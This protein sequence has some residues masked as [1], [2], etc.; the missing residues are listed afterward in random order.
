M[1][2]I[3]GQLGLN[4]AIKV[5]KLRISKACYAEFEILRKCYMIAF[6]TF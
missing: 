2:K 1:D 3:L 6:N 5:R 4:E